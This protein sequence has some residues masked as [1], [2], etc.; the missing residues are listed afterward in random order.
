MGAN[1]ERV[2]RACQEPT[3]YF[4]YRS[5]VCG[6]EQSILCYP[7]TSKEVPPPPDKTGE[8]AWFTF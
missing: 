1:A 2:G 3:P 5:M 7:G 6:T 4:D 8:E